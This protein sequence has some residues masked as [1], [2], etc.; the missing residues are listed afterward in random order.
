MCMHPLAWD[1]LHPRLLL[2]L[3]PEYNWV[4]LGGPDHNTATAWLA[5]ANASQS[6]A[7]VTVTL[8]VHMEGASFTVGPC[9]FTQPA[10]GL[11]T[12]FG[13]WDGAREQAHLGLILAGTDLAGF[14]SIMQLVCSGHVTVLHAARVV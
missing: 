9:S 3:L 13:A 5:T 12:T 14:Q 6:A 7:P 10:Y 8:P 11:L 4:L 2:L 1:I